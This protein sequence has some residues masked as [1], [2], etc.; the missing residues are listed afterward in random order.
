MF[1]SSPRDFA[2]ARKPAFRRQRHPR[3]RGDRRSD[4]G[5]GVRGLAPGGAAGCCAGWRTHSASCHALRRP[6]QRQPGRRPGQLQRR[7]PAARPGP[8]TTTSRRPDR[9]APGADP[10]AGLPAPRPAAIIVS[11]PRLGRPGRRPGRR[12]RPPDVDAEPRRPEGVGEPRRPPPRSRRPPA[13]RRPAR[14][15]RRPSRTA[16]TT[17]DLAPQRHGASRRRCRPARPAAP[18]PRRRGTNADGSTSRAA[19]PPRPSADQPSDERRNADRPACKR[20]T[21]PAR[22]AAGAPE[23]AGDPS[24]PSASRQSTTGAR[25]GRQPHPEPPAHPPAPACCSA[26]C[27]WSSSAC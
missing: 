5:P 14:R 7:A 26:R 15:T 13:R 8:T 20:G 4:A 22:T 19:P 16:T 6:D 12:P 21:P 24:R 17:G 18:P 1:L 27:C 25:P 9:S 10:G 11:A 2:G 23:H 3:H